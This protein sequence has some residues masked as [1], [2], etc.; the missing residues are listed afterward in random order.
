VP[1]RKRLLLYAVMQRFC[2]TMGTY[3]EPKTPRNVAWAA[4]HLS[5]VDAFM[6]AIDGDG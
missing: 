5:D 1:E 4:Q 3:W 2:A 6:D